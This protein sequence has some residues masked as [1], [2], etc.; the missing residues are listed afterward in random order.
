L[1]IKL[2]NGLLPLN[3]LTWLLIATIF[4]FPYE[5]LRIS[6]GVPFVL[7]FPG[8]TVVM[9]LFPK[10][11]GI[12]GIERVALSFGIS[13]TM[14]PLIGLILNYTPWGIT[15]ESGLYS[16]A[17][18][19]LIMSIIAWGRR[20]RLEEGE[21]F[22]IEFQLRLPNWGGSAWD[23]ALSLVLVI[24]ILGALGV[25]GYAIAAP[26]V[27]EKFTEFYILGQEGK[28]A[29][30]LEELKVGEEGKVVVG[31]INHEQR[32][33][34]FRVEVRINEIKNSEVEPIVLEND[35]KWEGEISFVPQVAGEDQK[36]ELLL[37][38]DEE[39]EPYSTPLRLWINV[40]ES[41]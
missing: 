20:R 7:F 39:T 15:L 2:G 6:I 18:F 41:R 11:E 36:L 25:L 1:R 29:D 14:V 26:K 35:E 31:I 13:I 33:V 12:S 5:V 22:N 19:I 10:K 24:A 27:G 21:R 28:A 34:S 40:I 16:I 30:Y 4:F 8:Y 23:K 32:T 38:K 9:A 37:Y 3:L 17:A